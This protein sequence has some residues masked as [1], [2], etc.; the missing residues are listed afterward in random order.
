MS[1]SAKK[2][3]AFVSEFEKNTANLAKCADMLADIKVSLL[4][5]SFLEP[6][7]GADGEVARS[8]LE[9]GVYLAVK[10]RDTE[11]FERTM[12]QL[13]AYYADYADSLS[14]SPREAH[15]V[16]LHLL[17][18]LTSESEYA[19]AFHMLLETLSPSLLGDEAVANVIELEQLLSDGRYANVI[20]L[21][22]QLSSGYEAYFANKL[23]AAV[24]SE[25]AACVGAAYNNMPV[26]T[27]KSLLMTESDAEFNDLVAQ[28]GWEV[29]DGVLNLDAG[30]TESQA[31]DSIPSLRVIGDMLNYAKELERIV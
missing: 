10:Q 13:R 28:E 1:A 23:R 19:A 18:V 26:Q 17:H 21:T 2:L 11:A 27:A 12:S 7:A 29:K 5:E 15:I 9:Y 3:D 4:E 24:K 30:R 20:E 16:S 31:A 8:V 25:M 14:P 22:S 6:G